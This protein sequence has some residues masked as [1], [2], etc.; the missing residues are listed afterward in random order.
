MNKI[1]FAENHFVRRESALAA[2]LGLTGSSDTSQHCLPTGERGLS[3]KVR[4]VFSHVALKTLRF[5]TGEFNAPEGSRLNC[6]GNTIPLTNHWSTSN[7]SAITCTLPS[8]SQVNTMA[9]KSG[10]LGFR[11]ILKCRQVPSSVVTFSL[12]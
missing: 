10:L 3:R 5:L 9:L 2:S 6:H 1:I 12:S 11:V 7:I 8:S 4:L